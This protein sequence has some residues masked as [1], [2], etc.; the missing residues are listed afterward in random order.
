MSS[1]GH[2]H[3]HTSKKS[4]NDRLATLQGLIG[5]IPTNPLWAELLARRQREEEER[6][7]LK[8]TASST[9]L[10]KAAARQSQ[11]LSPS[12]KSERE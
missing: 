2:G 3:V 4:D 12:R 5:R 11:L 10:K 7:R 8:K 1:D 9:S 6:R